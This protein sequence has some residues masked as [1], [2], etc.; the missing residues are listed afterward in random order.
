MR[1]LVA[2]CV[3]WSLSITDTTGTKDIFLYNGV[4]FAI[5]DHAPLTIMARYMLEQTMDH[6]IDEKSID[7]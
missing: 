3:Q 1:E 6:Q 7:F 5:V 4:S 2:V